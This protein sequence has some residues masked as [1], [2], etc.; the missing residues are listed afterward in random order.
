MS[1]VVGVARAV[2]LFRFAVVALFLWVGPLWSMAAWL[3]G[4]T[5]LLSALGLLM[6]VVSLR[7]ALETFFSKQTSKRLT[8]A[9]ATFH[10]LCLA[11]GITQLCW[12]HD[13]A[14]TRLLD[15]GSDLAV[16]FSEERGLV[17]VDGH[18]MRTFD[19]GAWTREERPGGFTFLLGSDG[20]ELWVAPRDAGAVFVH[21]SSRWDA[22]PRMSGPIAAAA[23]EG[24][25]QL[26][27]VAGRL[28]D[29]AAS[30]PP[31]GRVTDAALTRGRALAVGGELWWLSAGGAYEEVSPPNLE[32]GFWDVS[33]GGG[34]FYASLSV[35]FGAS[36]L[37]VGDGDSFE[38]RSPP[39]S[40][41]RE[42]VVN[43]ANGEEAVAGSWGEDVHFTRDGGRSWVALGLLGVQVRTLGVDWAERR[44]YVASSN[45]VFD[46]GIWVRALPE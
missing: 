13:A 6:D 44:V 46:K 26:V 24:G 28:D 11:I 7:T 21:R 22:E 43:P 9:S 31:V 20:D 33:G 10:A 27:V 16:T 2:H 45:L 3:V 4:A 19:G 17:V 1:K 39:C 12:P 5:L 41:V 23:R 35:R 32:R 8:W 38:V 15:S 18:G 14:W 30:S 42:I 25:R 37:F 34:L 40:D 29:S 36:H